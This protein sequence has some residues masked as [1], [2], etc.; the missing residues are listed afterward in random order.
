MVLQGVLR[1]KQTLQTERK[2]YQLLTLGCLQY[3]QCLQHV[4]RQLSGCQ[5]CQSNVQR[6]VA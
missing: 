4:V 5:L 2:C 3:W 1:S 6:L